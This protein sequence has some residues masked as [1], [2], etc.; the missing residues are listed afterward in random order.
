MSTPAPAS[1]SSPL[2]VSGSSPRP[3]HLFLW[4]AP[5]SLDFSH[6]IRFSAKV[7]A[8]H[9]TSVVSYTPDDATSF[10][11]I[12]SFSRSKL[13]L[14]QDLV[15]WILEATLGGTASLFSVVEVDH[16]V[17][18]FCVASSHVGFMICALKA[19]S[20]P[21]FIIIFHLWNETG[22]PLAK[23]SVIADHTPD[24]QW[25]P[26]RSKRYSKTFTSVA[27]SLRAQ[28][29][30]S[31]NIPLS[32]RNLVPIGRAFDR[33]KNNVSGGKKS[34]FSRLTFREIVRPDLQTGSH[35][36]ASPRVSD[37]AKNKEFIGQ[38]LNSRPGL[39][40]PDLNL[41]LS[42][43]YNSGFD[44]IPSSFSASPSSALPSS[45]LGRQC[46]RCLSYKH[47]RPICQNRV[48][49]TACFRLGH[50]ALHCR[51]PPRFAGLL[52]SG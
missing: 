20:C 13:R 42:L 7:R 37:Q 32:G 12:A 29:S 26:A 5:P 41:D 19:L 31:S 49:C 6:A 9:G 45:A 40:L 11:L 23:A 33:L 15:S 2:V 22:L 18:K 47:G 10:W 51:F 17:F 34:V 44:A 38:A 24:Y 30:K 25:L 36:A 50:I 8:I 46:T 39:N 4:M 52:L 27:K 16:W 48:R 35:P 21:G 28:S 43:K 1:T 3:I 14:D